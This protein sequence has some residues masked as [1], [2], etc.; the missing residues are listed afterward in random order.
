MPKCF[1]NGPVPEAP[2]RQQYGRNLTSDD[3]VKNSDNKECDGQA[4][5]DVKERALDAPP[6]LVH[7]SLRA[8]KNPSHTPASDL[9]KN[10][11][12][13]RD[14]DDDLRDV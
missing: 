5:C 9:Q 4:N 11:D 13:Q 1:G 7:G 10:D 12:D 2:S 6:R 8:S 14:T 3:H